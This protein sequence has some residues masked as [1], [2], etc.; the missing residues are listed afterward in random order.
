M[1]ISTFKRTTDKSSKDSGHAS[2]PKVKTTTAAESPL[3]YKT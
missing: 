3:F 2:M 1:S